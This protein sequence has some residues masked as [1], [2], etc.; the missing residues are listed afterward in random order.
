MD[1]DN[2]GIDGR[3]VGHQQVQAVVQPRAYQLE[4]FEASMRQNIIV[5]VRSPFAFFLSL[6]SFYQPMVTLYMYLGKYND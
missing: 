4:L 3:A 1:D 6:F 5:T 2:D